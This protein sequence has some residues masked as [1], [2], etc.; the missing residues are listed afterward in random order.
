MPRNEKSHHLFL[1]GKLLYLRP[2]LHLRHIY[3][4]HRGRLHLPEQIR[5]RG[6]LIALVLG[7]VMQ[8]FLGESLVLARFLVKEQRARDI[9]QAVERPRLGQRL[10]AS[11]VHSFQVRT[12]HKI[13][14][15]LVFTVLLPFLHH[16]VHHGR[17]YILD[18]AQAETNRPLL[19]HR[20]RRHTL[21]HIRP[22][23]TDLHPFAL[24][25]IERNLADVVQ[26]V[27]QNRSHELRRVM[28]LEV[29]RLVSDPSIAG[30]MRLVERIGREG[31][32]VRPD[33]LADLGI[34]AML[35]AALHETRLHLVQH[36]L[37][38]LPHRLAQ[39]IGIRLAEIGQL[40]RKQHHLLLIDRHPVGILEVFLHI[41]QI[42]FDLFPAELAVDELRDIF[43]RPGTVQGVHRDDILQAVRLQFPQ[44]LLHPFRFK[45]E[46]P[47]GIAPAEQLVSL[48]VVQ[49]NMVDVDPDAVPP[50]DIVQRPLD[51]RQRLQ[52]Q[53]VHLQQAHRLH[54][55]ALVLGYRHFRILGR[56]RGHVFHQIL[57]R[58]NHPAGMG[59][60]APDAAF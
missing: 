19:V 39:G 43:H 22:Q 37:F 50:L 29:S 34:V 54:V 20:E 28:R 10:H 16:Q 35:G 7:R 21:V 23:Q 42:V 32:P 46:Y 57:R 12:T 6:I 8:Q 60:H 15:I 49:R 14:D 30:G 33:L 51:D 45:L 44:V 52:A 24:I 38:L 26:V 53:E 40:L 41:R 1:V 58:D 31:L 2:R 59:S 9:P 47:V 36:I 3:L 18:A 56:P 48:M 25:H 4:R 13:H 5:L 11:P 17:P 55:L 27:G